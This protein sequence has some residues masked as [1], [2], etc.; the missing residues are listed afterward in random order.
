MI[1]PNQISGASRHPEHYD[2]NTSKLYAEVSALRDA[3]PDPDRVRLAECNLMVTIKRFMN[4]LQRRAILEIHGIWCRRKEREFLQSL[5]HFY[6]LTVRNDA[7]VV[8]GFLGQ[9]AN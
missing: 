6:E 5:H 3:V 2:D 9:E 1:R 8:L 7:G 4:I